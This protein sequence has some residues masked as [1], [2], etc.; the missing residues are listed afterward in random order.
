MRSAAQPGSATCLV[1][2]CIALSIAL[3]VLIFHHGLWEHRGALFFI[4][5]VTA[6]GTGF[7][8]RAAMRACCVEFPPRTATAGDF[9][10]Q[11]VAHKTDLVPS[12][13]GKWT[14]EQVAARIRDI[15]VEQLG[16]AETC[17]EDASFV[18]DLGMG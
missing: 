16:C 2:C 9:S 7:L 18:Q 11:I 1:V 6:V 13:P 15:T 17:R 8:A 3:A 12:T 5:S 10:C 4:T 14:C